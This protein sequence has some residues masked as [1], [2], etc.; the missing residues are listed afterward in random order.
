M[1]TIAIAG[2]EVGIP[3]AFG[4]QIYYRLA[5]RALGRG[6]ILRALG[7]AL[8]A[9]RF[10]GAY[11]PGLLDLAARL[12][13]L[14]DRVGERTVLTA[15]V[16]IAPALGWGSYHLAKLLTEAGD[17]AA[18]IDHY[19]TAAAHLPDFF[20]AWE[21]L[22]EALQRQ[23]RFRDA[24]DAFERA[25]RLNPGN[26]WPHHHRG[27]CL[28][29]LGEMLG[30][31]AAYDR[32]IALEP[33]FVWNHYNRADALAALHRW[34]EAIAAYEEVARHQGDLPYLR[35][36]L[37]AARTAL[38]GAPST[39]S[40]QPPHDTETQP[41]T[42][43]KPLDGTT[44]LWLA[45]AAEPTNGDLYRQVADQYRDRGDRPLAAIY[46]GIALQL[47]PGHP[48]IQHELERL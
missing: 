39:A 29:K 17:D 20:W 6:H 25:G 34:P 9:W 24:A 4:R 47:L 36:K 26:P 31:I 28:Q 12:R 46:Y 23:G 35:R 13:G 37:H 14:G 48:E 11:G 16:A 2:T 40:P 43:T 7:L 45:L 18:A 21:D 3:R 41:T 5:W 22:G 10:D 27:V 38:K 44:A 33:T 8:R 32:A 30:A 19:Q 42:N 15:A 1:R